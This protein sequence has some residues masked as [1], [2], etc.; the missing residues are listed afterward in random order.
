MKK[1]LALVAAFAVVTVVGCDTKPTTAASGGKTVTTSTSPA[2]T[3]TTT[4]TTIAK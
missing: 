1:I 3:A 4:S 2:T